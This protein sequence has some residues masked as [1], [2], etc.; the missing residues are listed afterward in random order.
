MPTV[1]LVFPQETKTLKINPTTV[2][3]LKLESNLLNYHFIANSLVLQDE[4]IIST[5]LD[6]IVMKSNEYQDDS[7]VDL[8]PDWLKGCFTQQLFP[9]KIVEINGQQYL[10]ES[11]KDTV[12][13][14]KDE[15]AE[16]KRLL[17]QIDDN[18]RNID[19]I[20][21]DFQNEM[22]RMNEPDRQQIQ[23]PRQFRWNNFLNGEFLWTLFKISILVYFLTRDSS[24]FRTLIITIVAILVIGIQSGFIPNI[25]TNF[26][27]CQ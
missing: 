25:C 23:Q 11:V 26:N 22:N 9:P 20:N 16:I 27:S 19:N 15:D 17:G 7:N 18:L 1:N 21:N 8:T 14:V 12:E 13:V 6:I 5:D 2:K 10:M 4:Q 24:W 3:Q